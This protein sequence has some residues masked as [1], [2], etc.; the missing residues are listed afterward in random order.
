[1]GERRGDGMGCVVK[2]LRAMNLRAMNL[3]FL[4]ANYFTIEF[5]LQSMCITA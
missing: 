2:N 4:F 3:R 1:M 5:G